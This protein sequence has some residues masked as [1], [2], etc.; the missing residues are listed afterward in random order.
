[1]AVITTLDYALIANRVYN[2]N[3]GANSWVVADFECGLFEEGMA[4]GGTSTDFKGCVYAHKTLKEVV[5]AIQGTVP[6][7]GGDLVA[8][9]Q[10]AIMGLVGML[11]HYCAA[12]NRLFERTVEVYSNHAISFVGHSLGGALA[13]VLGHWTGRPFVTF[14]APGMWMDIQRSKFAWTWSPSDSLRSVRGTFQGPLLGKLKAAAGRNFRNVLD[15]VSLYGSH[16]GPV[17]RFWGKGLHSMDDIE[18]RI[19]RSNWAKVSPFDP[20]MREWGEL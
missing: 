13:Q 15:P 1:M 16:Y 2:I 20:K 19:R 8:D 17:T 18:D 7:K 6:A 14:N 4:W 9:A 12:A 3:R 11:P 10:I 5:V